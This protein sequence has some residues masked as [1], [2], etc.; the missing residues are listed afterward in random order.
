MAV[1]ETQTKLLVESAEAVLGLH[2]F[3]ARDYTLPE[4]GIECEILLPGI[5]QTRF[6]WSDPRSQDHHLVGSTNYQFLFEKRQVDIYRA[7][8]WGQIRRAYDNPEGPIVV[9]RPAH[10]CQAV[11][12]PPDSHVNST[13]QL[14]NVSVGVQFHQGSHYSTLAML[15][16]FLPRDEI[17]VVHAGTVNERFEALMND[18]IGAAT[19]MEPWISLAEKRGCKR[20]VETHYQGVENASRGLTE[21]EETWQRVLTGLRK[22]V[23]LINED[24]RRYVHYLIEEMPERYHE[25]LTPDDFYL[26]RLRYA[27]P[28]PYTQEEFERVYRWMLTWDLVGPNADYSNLVCNVMVE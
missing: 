24:K 18:E 28:E 1:S 4:Q 15:E 5:R 26:P 23:R 2:W 27:E 20:I 17:N 8:E 25:E 9:K 21:N 3:V 19:L 14:A 12:V 6:D 16:G 11:F 13:V 10:V 22:A 7:C